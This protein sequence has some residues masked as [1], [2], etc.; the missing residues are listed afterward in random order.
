MLG[1]QWDPLSCSPEEGFLFTHNFFSIVSVSLI[2]L[3]HVLLSWNQLIEEFV[4]LFR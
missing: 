1:V 2:I 3:P 4:I